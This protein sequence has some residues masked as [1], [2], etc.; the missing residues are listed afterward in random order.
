MKGQYFRAGAGAVILNEA[1][2]VLALERSGVAG[3]WQFP[4]GGLKKEEEPLPGALR[5]IEEETGITAADLVLLDRYPEPLAYELPTELRSAKTGRG[6]TH[7]W[8]VFRHHGAPVTL[9]LSGEFQSSSWMPFEQLLGRV[10]EFRK[11]VYGRLYSWLKTREHGL[12]MF[13]VDDA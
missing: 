10:V 7:Y 2:Y 11:P 5:E 9:P 4:Q 8:F 13:S 12:R 1:G 6:Q 3:A